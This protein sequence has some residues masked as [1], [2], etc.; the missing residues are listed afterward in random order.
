[1]SPIPAEEV[2]PRDAKIAL[3]YYSH[4]V[5]ISQ[6]LLEHDDATCYDISRALHI[7]SRYVTVALLTLKAVGLVSCDYLNKH[8]TTRVW[9]LKPGF[10]CGL[11]KF[12][13][14]KYAAELM[15]AN[16]FVSIPDECSVR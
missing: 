7:D 8:M 15:T 1:M 11:Q 12:L 5:S 6:Y 3:R 14:D 10:R 13:Q 2:L 4:R 16:E 9:N